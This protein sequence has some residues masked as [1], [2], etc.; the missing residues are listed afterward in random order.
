[1]R[2]SSEPSPGRSA[3]SSA[4]LRP[5]GR[6]HVSDATH[7]ADRFGVGGIALY[8]AP[9]PGDAQIDRPVERF[10]LAVAGDLQQP[11]TCQRAIGVFHEQFQQIELARRESL[12]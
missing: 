1:M 7:G 2:S 10:S 8:F 12:L 11:I 9:Q 6:E 5:F 3:E 4:T